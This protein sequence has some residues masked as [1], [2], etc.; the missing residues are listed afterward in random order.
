LPAG[1]KPTDDRRVL[2]PEVVDYYRRG[3]ERD[4]L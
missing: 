1:A 2:N 4:R 3:E